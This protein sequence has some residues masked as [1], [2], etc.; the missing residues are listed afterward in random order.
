M[1]SS[2]VQVKDQIIVER[3]AVF[4]NS[5]Y[6]AFETQASKRHR[7]NQPHILANL[8][9][10]KPVDLLFLPKIKQW[11]SNAE[12]LLGKLGGGNSG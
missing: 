7:A 4:S 3:I 9:P 12:L 10:N 11:R 2:Q 5:H 1:A 8:T 6:F